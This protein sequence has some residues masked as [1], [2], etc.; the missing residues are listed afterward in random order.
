MSICYCSIGN[1]AESDLNFSM[2]CKGGANAEKIFL[3]S[4]WTWSQKNE[5]VHLCHWHVSHWAT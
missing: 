4:E 5:S 1:Y 2:I 3:E